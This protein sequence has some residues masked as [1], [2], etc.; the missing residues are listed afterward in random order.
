MSEHLKRGNLLWESSRMFLPEHKE[1]LL[2]L[3]QTEQEVPKPELD[4]QAFEEL[5]MTVL[6]ALNHT[7]SVKVHYW[8]DG[9]LKEESGIIAR[10]DEH[11]QSLILRD[12]H[13]TLQI[14]FS[15]LIH[16]EIL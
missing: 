4:E 12:A 2:K 7:L 10:V 11:N 1:A 6:N 8:D 3:K 16:V 5:G 9:Q 14:K 15:F 13:S